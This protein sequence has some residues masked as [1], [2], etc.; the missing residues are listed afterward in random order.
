MINYDGYVIQYDKV[1]LLACGDRRD[2]IDACKTMGVEVTAVDYHPA[3]IEYENYIVKDFIFDDV[4]LKAELVIH[5]NCEK[6]YY[7]IDYSGD[8][9]VIG[10]NKKGNGDCNPI[11]SCNQLIEQYKIADIYEEKQEEKY[12]FVWGRRE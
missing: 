6:T 3:Y 12:Y 10:H 7:E 2:L 11:E 8:I 1:I 5:A 4:Q 9:I